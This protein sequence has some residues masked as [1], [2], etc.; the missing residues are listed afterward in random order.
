MVLQPGAVA[1]GVGA[2][3]ERTPLVTDV[4][5]VAAGI[6]R[7]SLEA[8]GVSLH[9]FIDGPEAVREAEA[10]GTTRSL[11]AME[12]GG[13]HVIPKRSLSRQRADGAA[14]PVRGGS[15]WNGPPAPDCGNAGRLCAVME[16]KEEALALGVPVLAVRGR[17]GGSAVAAAAVNALLLLARERGR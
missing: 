4:R 1:A 12:T 14:G 8:L 6:H 3:R 15:P 2:L 13:R 17:K 10:R 11:V 7:P 16:S 5:M 9:C